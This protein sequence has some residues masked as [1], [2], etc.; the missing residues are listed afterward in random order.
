AGARLVEPDV[1]ALADPEDLEVDPAGPFDG[2]LV[3]PAVGFHLVA[4]DVAARDVDVLRL[5]VHVLEE[6][7]PHVPV[8]AVDAIR[9]HG[10][11]L[12][13]IERDDVGE[14]EALLAVQADQFAV[15]ADRRGARREP[16]DGVLASGALGADERRDAIRDE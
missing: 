16:E 15:Y 1:A 2:G 9:L 14:V 13:E 11:V 5:D 7:L 12:I 4:R 3:L 6:V 10:V 8:E